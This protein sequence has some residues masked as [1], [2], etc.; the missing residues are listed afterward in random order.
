MM[1]V[2]DLLNVPFLFACFALAAW[3]GYRRSQ[4]TAALDHLSSAR[5]SIIVRSQKDS[6]DP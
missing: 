4:R 2:C 6:F 1:F 5:R 3:D